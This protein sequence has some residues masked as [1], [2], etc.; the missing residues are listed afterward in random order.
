MEELLAQRAPRPD[1]PATIRKLPVCAAPPRTTATSLPPAAVVAPQPAAIA[2][3]AP[4][5][6]IAQPARIEPLAPSRHKL[7]MT[8]STEC[9]DKLERAR[10]LL[11]HRNPTGDLAEVVERALDALLENLEKERLGKSKRPLRTPR[12]AKAGHVTQAARRDVFERD[13]EQCSYVDA[14]DRR[15]PARGLLEVDH[16]DSKARG[17]S[18]DASN[19]RVLCRAHNRLHAEQ[20]FGREYV[21]SRIHSRQRKSESDQRQS[22]MRGPDDLRALPRLE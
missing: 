17:G 9:R 10:A 18:G 8:V 20:V 3:L 21:E 1:V 4:P 19:L 2:P 6:P 16:I 13:G 22:A 11:R 15:C 14:L 12:A 5:A 7:Q